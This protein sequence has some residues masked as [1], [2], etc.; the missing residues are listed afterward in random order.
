MRTLP[1][2]WPSCALTVQ[3]AEPL[4]LSGLSW[5]TCSA[6]FERVMDAADGEDGTTAGC[7]LET[8]LS[9]LPPPQLPPPP[10]AVQQPP[11]LCLAPASSLEGVPG[12]QASAVV[13]VAGQQVAAGEVEVQQV[14]PASAA[15]PVRQASP[16]LLHHELLL[17]LRNDSL[18]LTGWSSGSGSIGGYGGGAG[19]AGMS[20]GGGGGGGSAGGR[21]DDGF[22]GGTSLG[23]ADRRARNRAKQARFRE[24]KKVG[25]WGGGPTAGGRV[26]GKVGTRWTLAGRAG[27]SAPARNPTQSSVSSVCALCALGS[28]SAAT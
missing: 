24:R 3:G 15:A 16:G 10:F 11:P 18:Q 28:P 1:H 7:S 12:V 27:T 5:K 13:E 6:G 23:Q 19:S 14:L 9:L 26:Y 25:G 21:G 17:P 22:T 4:I 2:C 8:L 20:G